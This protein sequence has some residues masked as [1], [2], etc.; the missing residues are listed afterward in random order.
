MD[1]NE[2]K[3]EILNTA[4]SLQEQIDRV[5]EYYGKIPQIDMDIV[6]D[7]IRR[8]YEDLHTLN[9]LNKE[10]DPYNITRKPIPQK[11]IPVRKEQKLEPVPEEK[12]EPV[13]TLKPAPEKIEVKPDIV[14][15]E[16]E[17]VKE[18]QKAKA[19][20]EVPP[21]EKPPVKEKIIPKAEPVKAAPKK[22]KTPTTKRTIDMYADSK[23]TLADKFQDNQDKSIAAKMQKNKI[24]DLKKAIGINEKFLFIKEL[25]DGN[26]TEYD[27]A[28]KQLNS[29]DQR[30]AALKYLKELQKKY[31]WDEESEALNQLIGLIEKRYLE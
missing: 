4:L 29:F 8:I 12:P 25:F 15:N 19:P 11:E 27:N 7:S 16:P 23:N 22:K 14:K 28:V 13:T 18:P 21:V 9:K 10:V 5:M 6:M 24:S 3:S 20:I 17:E 30:E 31:S 2:L 1:I 26:T